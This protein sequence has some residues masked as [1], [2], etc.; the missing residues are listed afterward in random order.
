VRRAR[1]RRCRSF[2]KKTLRTCSEFLRQDNPYGMRV[3]NRA[4]SSETLWEWLSDPDV[5]CPESA[6]LLKDGN[7]SSVWVTRVDNRPLVVK[8][9]NVKGFWHGLKLSLRPGRALASWRNAHRLGL[10]GIPTPRPVALAKHRRERLQPLAWLIAEW[11][12][13]PNALQWFKDPAVPWAEKV[14]MARRI[15]DLFRALHRERLRHGDT[16]ATNIII[17][18]RGPAL[19]D[20]DAMRR[21]RTRWG[22][23]RAWDADIARFARN[24]EENPELTALFSRVMADL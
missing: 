12:P 6:D 11:L 14:E 20:L 22:F 9:Y 10:Y 3:V 1:E 19:V 4:Q 2:L 16:K 7:T 8:R 5:G 24:W 23:A 17:S 15:A 21:Y 13:G 18:V